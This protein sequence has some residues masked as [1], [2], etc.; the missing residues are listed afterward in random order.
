MSDKKALGWV[1]VGSLAALALRLWGITW[2][3][4]NQDRAFSYH[5]DEGVNLVNGV[6]ENGVPRPHLELG[7]Y[8]YGSL[9]FYLWQ[10][11][12]AINRTYGLIR[13]S[14]AGVSGDPV[15]DSTAA[16]ILMGR[17]V[18]AVLG[19]LT[20]WAVFA[21]GNR[22]FG[23][24][25]GLAA[26][27]AYAIMP[28][29]VV[30]GHY[31]TVD[32]PATFFIAV[33]LAFGARLLTSGRSRD[34]ALAGLFC[35]LAA[36]CKY[37]SALVLFAPLA[38]LVSRRKMAVGVG[39]REPWILLGA[40]VAGFLAGCPGILLN[41]P[42]FSA[43]FAF[44][45]RKSAEGMGLLFAG[46][47]NGWLYPILVSLRYGLGVPLLL[48]AL[49]ALGYALLR[50]TRQDGYLLAF[51]VPYYLL[52]GYAQVRFLRY[53]IPLLPV[54]AVLI[55]RL[56]TEP[57]PD[58][59]AVSRALSGVGIAVGLITLLLSMAWVGL[60][61]RPDSR[62]QALAYLRREASPNS[63]IAFATTPWYYTPPLLPEFTAPVSGAARR[64]M[65]LQAPKQ[66]VLRLPERDREWDMK[67]FGPPLP[68]F[69]ILSDIESIH[70][71][72]L[73]WEPARSFFAMLRD[74][75]SARVFENTL[76]VL[77]IPFKKRAFV[78]DDWLYVNPRITV[79]KR[80]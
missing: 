8:N 65:I 31:A 76:S 24:A 17:L 68:D 62:D 44:E 77:G 21:I 63:I 12:V 3:L 11:V 58:R 36:A 66:Y 35:G 9:Y 45:L 32:V 57:R 18:T 5:P 16:L 23:R 60:M 61:T 30:H 67:V 4:P 1:A 40:A 56:L 14:P 43:D 53:V 71:L 74:H 78:P 54:L 37:N 20:V 80:R 2:G 15:P 50:R 39:Q 41:W 70:P 64:E 79:Y 59:P 48:F 7:F 55:G 19:A 28:A 46:T 33:A 72:R 29:A 22:L 6:L 26:G 75:Y 10:G 47:G 42:K 38:A 69:V 34:L 13:L 25:A 51:F 73:N 27:A 49:V 52:L